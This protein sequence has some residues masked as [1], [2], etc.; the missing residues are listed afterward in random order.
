MTRIEKRLRAIAEEHGITYAPEMS[1]AEFCLAIE[2]RRD[3]LSPPA[4]GCPTPC[5]HAF[6]GLLVGREERDEG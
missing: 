5:R 2:F 4:G 3:S 6:C 1:L